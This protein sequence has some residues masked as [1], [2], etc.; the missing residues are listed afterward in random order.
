[1]TLARER[2]VVAID[3]DRILFFILYETRY[4][5]DKYRVRATAIRY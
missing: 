4:V 2:D 5:T 1:M 3:E